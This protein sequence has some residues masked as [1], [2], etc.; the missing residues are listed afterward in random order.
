MGPVRSDQNR[1]DRR[2]ILII[3]DD[4]SIRDIVQITLE[5]LAGWQVLQAASGQEGLA[6]ARTSQ[7]DALLLDVMMPGQDGI[8]TLAQLQVDPAIAHL[9]TI[10]LTA[11]A[12]SLE[13]KHLLNL[14]CA[15]LIVKPFDVHQLVPQI[16]AL[17]GW[18][19]P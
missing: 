15:G 3:D 17:L 19:P 1:P 8:Q 16:C 18:P 2:C 12:R 6:L 13:Q 14:G 9:S 10:F 7:P 5:T 4:D 11:K